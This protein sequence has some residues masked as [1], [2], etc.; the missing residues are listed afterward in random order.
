MT[1]YVEDTDDEKESEELGIANIPYLNKQDKLN[2]EKI[3]TK[4][5]Y[6]EPPPR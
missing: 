3:D 1:L 5:R 2:K 4:Q 6:S